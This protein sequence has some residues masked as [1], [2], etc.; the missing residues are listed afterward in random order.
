MEADLVLLQRAVTV[1][2][3]ISLCVLVGSST[4][5]LWLR[6]ARSTWAASLLP[7]LRAVA[8]TTTGVAISAYVAILWVEAASMAEVP[9]SEALPAVRSVV[10]ATH[11]GFAW[12]IGAAALVVTA[13]VC[14]LGERLQASG[15]ASTVRVA[16]IALLLYS[17]SMVSHAGAGGNFTWAV[18]VDWV[19]LV[20]ISVWVGEVLIAGLLVLR[21]LPDDESASRADCAAYIEAL[22]HSA[23]ISLVGIFV[24][25]GI[26]TLRVVEIPQDLVGNPYG[27]ALIIKV[28]FVLC[29]AALGGFNRFVVMPSLLRSLKQPGRAERGARGRFARILQVEAAFLILVIL[30][31]AVLTSTSPPM[32]P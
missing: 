7:S 28:G 18:A 26:S 17:R 27:T 21:R 30:A 23:T 2:L 11:Y 1:I 6:S 12:M 15:I 20:L 24:T 19:H 22:S 10:T 8:L 25:G 13:T 3:N 29:A 16:A 9:L 32:A 31:A 4:A 5:T 14:S